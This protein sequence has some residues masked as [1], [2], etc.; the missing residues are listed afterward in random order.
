MEKIRLLFIDKDMNTAEI[1]INKLQFQSMGFDLNKVKRHKGKRAV[2]NEV[3]LFIDSFK[4]DK[5]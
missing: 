4:K 5:E 1:E 3:A 2:N